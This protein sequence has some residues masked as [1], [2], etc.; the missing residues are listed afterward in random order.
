MPSASRAEA[1]ARAV[2]ALPVW[3][4]PCVFSA[5]IVEILEAETAEALLASDLELILE[6]LPPLLVFDESFQD[7]VVKCILSVRFHV[8]DF[9]SVDHRRGRVKHLVLDAAE[10]TFGER[11]LPLQL[12]AVM[13]EA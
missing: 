1:L 7:Y 12:F 9:D 11:R 10:V 13:A 4:I 5:C 6:R 8:A 2:W 3:V